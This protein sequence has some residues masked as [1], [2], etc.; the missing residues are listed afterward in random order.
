VV[1]AL[2]RIKDRS[3]WTEEQDSVFVNPQQR[4][5]SLNCRNLERAY[6]EAHVQ[7][8][9]LAIEFLVGGGSNIFNGALFGHD[10]PAL[11]SFRSPAPPF[12]C[13]GD[14]AAIGSGVS[15]QA[16]NAL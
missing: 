2:Q 7:L 8:A 13:G 6:R 3:E 16:K 11:R 9:H 4:G 14:G 5:V 1:E 10:D 12:W 15:P